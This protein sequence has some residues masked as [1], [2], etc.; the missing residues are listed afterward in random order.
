MNAREKRAQSTAR[1]CKIKVDSEPVSIPL[2][3]SLYKAWQQQFIKKRGKNHDARR[4][5]LKNL[6]R[7][8]YKKGFE[9]GRKGPESRPSQRPDGAEP[10]ST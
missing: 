3:E 2:G 7:A 10:A 4:K 9:D 6:I 8:A 1:Q 5:T